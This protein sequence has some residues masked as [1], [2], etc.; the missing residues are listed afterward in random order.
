MPRDR[1]QAP[2]T[3]AG[4]HAE[5]WRFGASPLVARDEIVLRLNGRIGHQAVPLLEDALRR[6]P[7]SLGEG[8]VVLDLAGVD[9][10]SSAA[11]RTLS[12]LCGRLDNA[13]RRLSVRNL[14]DPVRIVMEL[15]GLIERVEVL[16]RRPPDA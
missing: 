11:L 14:T 9:Y 12:T 5:R 1:Q 4:A 10:L 3:T 7:P 13:G 6:L 15:S 8:R 2:A 16:E